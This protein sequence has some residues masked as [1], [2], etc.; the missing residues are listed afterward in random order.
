MTSANAVVG[1]RHPLHPR[2]LI[3][4]HMI[5]FAL[6][7]S[8]VFRLT[9]PR[10]RAPETGSGPG[11]RTWSQ[12]RRRGRPRARTEDETGHGQGQEIEAG[13]RRPPRLQRVSVAVVHQALPGRGTGRSPRS[14]GI[15]VAPG[16]RV[17]PQAHLAQVQD[18][19]HPMAGSTRRR[20][21]PSEGVA[22]ANSC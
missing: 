3:Q 22:S 11:T 6:I 14:P 20:K 8:E 13:R 17:H 15:G 21:S 19:S 1:H 16:H 7:L 4:T 9:V 10:V 18:Q 12:S 5:E 2:R